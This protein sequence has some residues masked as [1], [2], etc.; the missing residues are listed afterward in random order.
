MEVVVVDTAGDGARTLHIPEGLD[1][2]WV[3]GRGLGHGPDRAAGVAAATAQVIALIEDHTVAESGWAEALIDA[4]RG[5]WGVVGYAFK[6]AEPSNYISRAGLVS[7]AGPWLHPARRR[8]VQTLPLSNVS[9]KAEA[10]RDA[11]DDPGSFLLLDHTLIGQFD[12]VGHAMLLEPGAVVAHEYF[13]R[14]RPLLVVNFGHGR[15]LAVA[16]RRTWGWGRR[17]VWA[18]GTPVTAP[19]VRAWR[20][21]RSLSGWRAFGRALGS[22]PVLALSFSA[23]GLGESLGYLLGP[24]KW[25][26]RIERYELGAPR[27]DVLAESSGPIPLERAQ[28]G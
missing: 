7:E 11:T 4:H 3:D 21:A 19:A 28:R 1:P 18:L 10:L 22:A 16:R 5:P 12:R 20:L 2:V 13:S 26:E 25:P 6:L 24:G 27:L 8:R 23:A 17:L 9:F 15:L 14:L